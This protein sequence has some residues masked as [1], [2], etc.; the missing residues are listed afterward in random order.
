MSTSSRPGTTTAPSSSTCASSE[1][2]TEISMSVA[3]RCRRPPAARSMMPARI[4]TVVRV[5]T[6]RRRPGASRRARPF[7]TPR[8]SS[9][10]Q[11]YLWMP[12]RK[13]LVVVVESVKI[14]EDGALPLGCLRAA[15]DGV[16]GQRDAHRRQGASPKLPA[17]GRSPQALSTGL[18]D[19]RRQ[20]LHQVVDVPVFLDELGDLRG[21]VDDG[22]VVAPAELLADLRQ[23]AVGELAGG[24]SRPG[25]GRRSAGAGRRSAPAWTSRTARRR[26][27]GSARRRSR[28]SRPGGR[29]PSAPPARAR[30]SSAGRSATRTRRRA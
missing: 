15:V 21:R 3:L 26:S 17:R 1:S 24:T 20:L 11:R 6:P 30:P 10:R 12:F 29:R 16:W 8:A 13:P 25:A 9:W 4:W 2:R 19:A 18:L 28:A 5:E 22:R 14:G 23:R 7:R 27:A